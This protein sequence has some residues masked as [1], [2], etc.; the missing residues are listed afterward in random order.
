MMVFFGTTAYLRGPNWLARMV[1]AYNRRGPAALYGSTGNCG[2]ARE[3]CFPHIRTTGLW[4]APILVNMH[5]LRVTNPA[6]RYPYE[7]GPAC[8]T[9][10]ARDKGYSAFVC[11]WHNE[12]EWPA[13]DAIP[14]GFHQGNQSGVIVG[15]RLCRVPYGCDP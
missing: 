7:H 9:Q 15:D 5:P 12:Y 11:D 2:D 4:C 8:L 3:G 14:N 13:W 6:Q 1:Q 10:W